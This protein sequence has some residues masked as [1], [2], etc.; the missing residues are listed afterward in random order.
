MALRQPSYLLLGPL[1]C[2]QLVRGV[3]FEG[4]NSPLSTPT[5]AD[6]NGDG[7]SDIV[8]GN[9]GDSHRQYTSLGNG[10]F[11]PTQ[12]IA[13]TWCGLSNLATHWIDL[14]GDGLIDVAC[15]KVGAGAAMS[16]ARN[17]VGGYAPPFNLVGWC[18]GNPAR[19][20]F[21]TVT[22]GPKRQMVC[23]QNSGEIFV[24]EFAD[25]LQGQNT[26]Q[27]HVGW[28]INNADLV[29]GYL[30]S[31]SLADAICHYPTAGHIYVRL[32]GTALNAYT[33]LGLILE[34]WCVG[35]V[36]LSAADINGDGISDLLCHHAGTGLVEAVI[37]LSPDLM[38]VVPVLLTDWCI[39]EQAEWTDVDGDHKADAVCI[40][41]DSRITIRRSLGN[42]SF[43]EE[44]EPSSVGGG[45]GI[46]EPTENRTRAR[47]D[48]AAVNTVLAVNRD[49]QRRRTVSIKPP[50][51]IVCSA[52]WNSGAQSVKAS[53]GPAVLVVYYN[54]SSQR[55][56]YDALSPDSVQSV[57]VQSPIGIATNDLSQELPGLQG[58]CSSQETCVAQCSMTTWPPRLTAFSTAAKRAI[59]WYQHDN[60]TFTL[61]T[62]RAYDAQD[63]LFGFFVYNESLLCALISE[64][65][66]T[67]TL[68]VKDVVTGQEKWS[69]L[70]SGRRPLI[71]A[72]VVRTG[73][74]RFGM[75]RLI[76]AW[77]RLFALDSPLE[78]FLCTIDSNGLVTSQ[79]ISP[80][81]WPGWIHHEESSAFVPFVLGIEDDAGDVATVRSASESVV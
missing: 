69:F 81:A 46:P 32:T 23:R 53:S 61:E 22:P 63:G 28:C 60:D 26:V 10:I 16:F 20:Y 58:L 71:G 24:A 75:V 56:F 21:E 31:D 67:G 40:H 77:R 35:S 52:L 19:L 42:G 25:Q 64:D 9:S 72:Y 70:P 76:I 17:T 34:N 73:R 68:L 7:R 79:R 55:G 43:N 62:D 1:L 48:S 33:D 18:D 3:L 5:F 4:C 14:T 27:W 51:Q 50:L 12:T 59:V 47:A 2:F 49:S 30:N 39:G 41:A 78:V 74:T 36:A 44:F 37:Y 65:V 13:D 80:R 15:T 45:D 6:L 29:F 66:N 38:D 8:C 11:V 54:H 57:L